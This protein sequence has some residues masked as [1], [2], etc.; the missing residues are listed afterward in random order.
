MGGITISTNK[1][2]FKSSQWNN[3]LYPLDNFIF[4]RELLKKYINKFWK[5]NIDTIDRTEDYHIILLARIRRDN[6]QIATIGTL[7]KLNV[8]DKDSLYNYLVAI[9]ELKTG[10]Y[11]DIPINGIVFSF[12]IRQGIAPIRTIDKEIKYQ[13][14][15]HFK[16][17]ITMDPLKYGK[18]LHK[19]DKTYFIQLINNN[20]A[21]IDI[22]DK[23]NSVKLFK[24][25]ELKFEWIDKY[26]DESSFIR[27]IG[28]KTFTFVNDE[29][30]LLTIKKSSKFINRIKT[31]TKYNNNILTM[32]LE[33]RLI[34]NKP[35]IIKN[36]KLI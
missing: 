29:L 8:D 27:D 26:I 13:H 10:G 24:K 18:L 4:T 5:E 14:Y 7:Q 11:V 16:L 6:G 21:I 9:I 1:Y 22:I 20:I 33:T 31:A 15:H 23:M 25:G 12:G 3:I 17:P 28:P 19:T 32:D 34:D 2:N 36:D 30:K 35:Y